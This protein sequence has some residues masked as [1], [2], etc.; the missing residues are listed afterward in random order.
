MCSCKNFEDEER[1]QAQTAMDVHYNFFENY[2]QD[3]CW[4]CTVA[5]LMLLRAANERRGETAMR[6]MADILKLCKQITEKI[7]VL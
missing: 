4:T 5:G 7:L 6:A 2:D 1:C 3:F